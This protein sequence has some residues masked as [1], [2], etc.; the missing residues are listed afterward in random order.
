MTPEQAA[1]LEAA[2]GPSPRP[3]PT[4]RPANPTCAPP[5]NAA[6]KPSPRCAPPPPPCTPAPTTPT[7]AP[8]P[9]STSPSP[10]QTSRTD[11]RGPASCSP[12]TGAPAPPRRR[13]FPR[14][15]PPAAPA[16]SS[17]PPPT[18]PSY[19]PESA[20]AAS[21]ATPPSCST[22]S[23]PAANPPSPASCAS[24]TRG[25]RR[26][27]LL[28]DR[29]CTYP[30]CTAPAA[31]T[32][33]HHVLHWA[34][35]GPTD[36]ANAA[37]LCPR[38]HTHVHHRRLWATVRKRR[39]TAAT[40][41]SGTSPPAPTT[42]TS[43]PSDTHPTTA[44]APPPEPGC[45][46]RHGRRTV[47][48]VTEPPTLFLTVGL[49][50]VGKTTRAEELAAEHRILRLT[51][52]DW[53]APLFGESDA[54]G[55]RDV[56]EGRMVWAAHEVLRSGAGGVL[57]FGCWSPEERYAIRA[58]AES[59][60]GRFALEVVRRAR[61]AAATGAAALARPPRDDVRDDRGRHHDRFLAAVRLPD[62][63]DWPAAGM[64]APP[65]G[66]TTWHRWASER[67]PT[68]PDLSPT[69]ARRRAATTLHPEGARGR[70]SRA[71]EDEPSAVVLGDLGAP[72]LGSRPPLPQHPSV[73]AQRCPNC[74]LGESSSGTPTTTRTRASRHASRSTWAACVG[75][76]V[77][78]QVH[79]EDRVGAA[80]GQR[81]V[82]RIAGQRRH[83]DPEPG[84]HRTEQPHRAPRDVRRGDRPPVGRHAERQEPEAAPQLEHGPPAHQGLARAYTGA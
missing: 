60:G 25:Q 63:D 76:E 57:D 62:D 72:P 24:T 73:T 7:A 83:V 71:I 19:P 28:R 26:H 39:M 81:D 30:G 40:T 56:L 5:A 41:W 32:R 52:D 35:G 51:P 3:P 15:R 79:R 65:D 10:S 49:P 34:D 48:D 74:S 67:W 53:M 61:R 70:T 77:L 42:D 36:V 55:R 43:P 50:G 18:A 27:P 9:P 1:T 17:R 82:G 68:L 33:A 37:L 6:S 29:G 21:A 59:A 13:P 64:P 22:C 2:I 20:S 66:H 80:V 8:T 54:D 69:A 38:H 16:P 11:E 58:I 23:A 84:S 31:W 14:R 44:P 45:R 75:L 78:Q 46:D 47:D 4:T 12:T